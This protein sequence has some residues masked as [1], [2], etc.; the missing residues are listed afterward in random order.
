MKLLRRLPDDVWH[1]YQAELL[2]VDLGWVIFRPSVSFVPVHRV[3]MHPQ[4]GPVI[5]AK[6]NIYEVDPDTADIHPTEE[7]A[8]AAFYGRAAQS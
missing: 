5:M 3:L 1:D 4:D 8:L 2:R 7:A 6:F